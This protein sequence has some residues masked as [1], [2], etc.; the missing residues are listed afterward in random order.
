MK[1]LLTLILILVSLNL[2]SQTREK[3]KIK[4]NPSVMILSGSGLLFTYG[5]SEI[6]Y[7]NQYNNFKNKKIPRWVEPTKGFV[8]FFGATLT[9]QGLWY[10]RKEISFKD[11]NQNIQDFY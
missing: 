1:K 6:V 10:S 7:P 5:V 11:H 2:L 9:I 8:F 3:K 4:I